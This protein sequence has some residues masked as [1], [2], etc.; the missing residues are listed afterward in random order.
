M[1]PSRDIPTLKKTLLIDSLSR[2][3]PCTARRSAA[4]A[5]NRVESRVGGGEFES[6]MINGIS[7]QP[8]TRHR[9]SSPA[10][11]SKT[12]PNRQG[13]IHGMAGMPAMTPGRVYHGAVL[14]EISGYDT[15]LVTRNSKR[16]MLAIT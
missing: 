12:T 14:L 7:V 13:M 3:R 1:K 4:R 9:C 8:R 15:P 10:R 2:V 16:T 5:S 6:F 11:R